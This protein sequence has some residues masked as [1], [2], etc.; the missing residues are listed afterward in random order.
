MMKTILFAFFGVLVLGHAAAWAE[1]ARFFS[2]LNDVPLMGGL[3]ELPKD[4][5]SFDKPEGRIVETAAASETIN[6]NEIRA[7]YASA[8][9]QLGWAATGPD[10]YARGGEKL[11]LRLESA[12]SLNI[13]HFSLS[14]QE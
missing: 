12:K 5:V 4:G 13:V 10:A 7:F 11:T 9:P 3:Y 2:M 6:S 14:P 8:L 1:D